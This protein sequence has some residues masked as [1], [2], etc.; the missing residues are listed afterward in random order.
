M[1]YPKESSH[2][3]FLNC[4]VVIM[5]VKNRLNV[6][7]KQHKTVSEPMPKRDGQLALFRFSVLSM[8]LRICHER[9]SL[10]A[11]LTSASR[12]TGQMSYIA[13][14]AWP[15]LLFKRLF[16]SIW[17]GGEETGPSC[18]S[19]GGILGAAACAFC[20]CCAC[21]HSP[22][23]EPEVLVLEECMEPSGGNEY[24]IDVFYWCVHRGEMRRWG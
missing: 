3:L 22:C 5:V 17:G 20:H 18:S 6:G 13:P 21:L 2:L 4:N 14:V 12:C 24:G 11:F 7:K 23:L 19:L 15:P 8:T 10:L 1:V 16:S 9:S